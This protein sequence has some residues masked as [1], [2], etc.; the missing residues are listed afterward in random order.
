MAGHILPCPSTWVLQN[1]R[2]PQQEFTLVRNDLI[3]G[4]PAW[5]WDDGKWASGFPHEAV[6]KRLE[7]KNADKILG[8]D[9]IND[10]I[11]RAWVKVLELKVAV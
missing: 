3:K 9:Y 2:L 4:V 10:V 7:D 6:K 8:K 1:D 5:V 11:M